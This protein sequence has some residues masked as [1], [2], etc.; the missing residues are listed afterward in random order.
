MDFVLIPSEQEVPQHWSSHI[1]DDETQWNA[2][3]RP[4]WSTGG[5]SAVTQ[6]GVQ[7]AETP[8]ALNRC[9]EQWRAGLLC[10]W[11]FYWFVVSLSVSVSTL[12][13][14][15]SA[16]PHPY[17]GEFVTSLHTDLRHF[18]KYRCCLSQSLIFFHIWFFFLK[19]EQNWFFVRGNKLL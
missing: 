12:L 6:S 7:V 10:I 14:G 19:N 17:S 15:G 4:P 11:G 2:G 13:C 8:S 18:R 1:P 16:S 5:S 9:S 3:E